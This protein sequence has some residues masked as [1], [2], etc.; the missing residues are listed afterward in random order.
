MKNKNYNIVN[1]TIQTG[2]AANLPPMLK[3]NT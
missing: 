3:R 2:A 1:K